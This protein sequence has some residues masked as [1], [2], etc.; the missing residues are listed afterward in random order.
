MFCFVLRIIALF[1]VMSSSSSKKKRK[2]LCPFS[3]A[4]RAAKRK[5]S[6]VF[7]KERAEALTK[8]IP[9]FYSAMSL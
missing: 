9:A 8:Y 2:R 3:S 4:K 6:K 5:T 1:V 7:H